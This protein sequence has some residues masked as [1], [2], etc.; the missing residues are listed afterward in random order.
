MEKQTI[1]F[2]DI[3]IRE[4]QDRDEQ[5]I[6]LLFNT[7]DPRHQRNIGY[8]K[9]SNPNSVNHDFLSAVAEYKGEIVA[10]Y[11]LLGVDASYKQRILRVGFGQQAVAH[12]KFRNLNIIVNLASYIFRMA[13]GKYAFL[14]AFPNDTFFPVKTSLLG[15]HK[16]GIFNADVIDLKSLNIK[17]SGNIT[18]RQINRFEHALDNLFD[19]NDEDRLYFKKSARFLNWRFFA[20]PINYYVVYA[21]YLKN[22]IVGYIV[23]K[24][25]YQEGLARSIGHFVDYEVKDADTDI[26]D[27]LLKRSKEFFLFHGVNEIVFWNRSLRHKAFFERFITKQNSGFKTNCGILLFDTANCGALL[28]IDNWSFS[29]ANSDA[30]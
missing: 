5:G 6:T 12:K 29:M 18:V 30:F 14:Y 17:N 28:N 2:N 4:Y 20:H 26:L 24:I 9:W 7:S 10:H 8:W 13:E 22:E 25:Y 1:N 16:A 15:W 3:I 19:Q 27:S 21:A 11:S 23:L